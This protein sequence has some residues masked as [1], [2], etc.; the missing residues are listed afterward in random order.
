MPSSGVANGYAMIS[1][2]AADD[3]AAVFLLIGT[4]EP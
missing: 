2:Q 1:K 4:A 3:R